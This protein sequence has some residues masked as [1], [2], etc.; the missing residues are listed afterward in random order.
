MNEIIK[1]YSQVFI[2][3]ANVETSRSLILEQL[4]CFGNGH[5]LPPSFD[6][7]VHNLTR[8]WLQ[9]LVESAPD[10]IAW[11]VYSITLETDN[12]LV[13]SHYHIQACI[14]QLVIALSLLTQTL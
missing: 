1:A 5:M 4:I 11:T 2:A 8:R 12:K 7:S 10:V 3:V 9:S 13:S 14:D 6:P